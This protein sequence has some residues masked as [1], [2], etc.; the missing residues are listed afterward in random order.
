MVAVTVEFKTI[1]TGVLTSFRSGTHKKLK[2]F[3]SKLFSKVQ[4]RGQK[5]LKERELD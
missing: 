5:G 1:Q 4:A 3:Q 2:M